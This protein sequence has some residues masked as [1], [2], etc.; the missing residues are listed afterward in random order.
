MIFVE[1]ILT[2]IE[3]PLHLKH[4]QLAGIHAKDGFGQFFLVDGVVW[5][6]LQ[7]D[8]LGNID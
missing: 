2:C 4:D 3:K 7:S 8:R 1:I 5:P 6:L